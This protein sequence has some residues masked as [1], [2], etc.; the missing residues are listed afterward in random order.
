[1]IRQ[2]MPPGQ[3]EDKETQESYIEGN[4]NEGFQRDPLA[5][6]LINQEFSGPRQIRLLPWKDTFQEKDLS[7]AGN[8]DLHHPAAA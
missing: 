5:Q 2:Q 3:Q 1:M 6:R 4:Q 8:R 7:A